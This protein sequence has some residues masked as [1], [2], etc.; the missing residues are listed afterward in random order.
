ML[1]VSEWGI[2]LYQYYKRHKKIVYITIMSKDAFD[3]YGNNILITPNRTVTDVEF[4]RWCEDYDAVKH[5]YKNGDKGDDFFGGIYR[6]VFRRSNF[7][8]DY[9]I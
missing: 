2:L 4:E 7:Y 9:I 6:K 3:K 8:P 1:I 5:I